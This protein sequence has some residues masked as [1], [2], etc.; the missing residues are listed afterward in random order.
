MTAT[1]RIIYPM[2]RTKHN[3]FIDAQEAGNIWV[4][5][6]FS[7]SCRVSSLWMRSS[8]VAF[9]SVSLMMLSQRRIFSSGPISRIPVCILH[10]LVN[11]FHS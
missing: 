7:K 5:H 6:F 3:R 4:G 9:P 11:R 1:E 2:H 8:G 10:L